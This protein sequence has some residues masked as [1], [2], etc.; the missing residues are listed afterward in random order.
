MSQPIGS[1]VGGPEDIAMSS[2]LSGKVRKRGRSADRSANLSDIC[3]SSQPIREKRSKILNACLLCDMNCVKDSFITCAVC[4][5]CTHLKCIGFSL[6]TLPN[7]TELATL[8][9]L[10][11]RS[12]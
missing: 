11:C 5:H 8:F 10:T 2:Q 9:G 6:D 7:I 4:N 3:G 1:I 12:C